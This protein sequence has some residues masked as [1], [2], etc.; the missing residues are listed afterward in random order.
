MKPR[1]RLTPLTQQ[2]KNYAIIMIKRGELMPRVA[3]LFGIT[4]TQLVKEVKI[5]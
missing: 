2:E 5:K 4:V 3:E 1:E